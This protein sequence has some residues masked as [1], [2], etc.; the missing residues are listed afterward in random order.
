VCFLA[1]FL[2]S[3]GDQA[4]AQEGHDRSAL[5]PA[6]PALNDGVADAPP[7]EQAR[8]AGAPLQE[9]QETD[10]AIEPSGAE[11]GSASLDGST[12]HAGA[13]TATQCMLF[14]EE[15]QVHRLEGRLHDAEGALAQCVQTSCPPMIMDDCAQWSKEVNEVMPRVIL[16]ARGDQGDIDAA[17]VFIND[18]QVAQTL[19]REPLRIDPGTHR[20]R[21]E[22]PDGQVRELQL[23]LATGEPLRVLELDFRTP[24]AQPSLSHLEREVPRLVPVHPMRTPALVLGAVSLLSASFAIGFGVDALS[25]K[26]KAEDLCAPNCDDSVSRRVKTS[27]TISDITGVTAIATAVGATVLYF[28]GP[29]RYVPEDSLTVSALRSVDVHLAPGR[30]ELSV[31]GVF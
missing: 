17:R 2:L 21:V 26:N 23:I 6:A 22:L 7:G 4:F 8:S 31:M 24:P 25:E 16:R 10:S 5:P 12:S 13:P 15:A 9:S 30:G 20:L 29:V 14:H 18:V 11:T 19:S 3:G 1:L 28:W 27:A